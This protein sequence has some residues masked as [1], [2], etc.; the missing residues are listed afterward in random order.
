M[1]KQSFNAKLQDAGLER[2]VLSAI[3]CHGA[4]LFLDMS[5]LLS[6]SDFYWHQNQ[7]LYHV[8]SFLVKENDTQIFDVPTILST[9]K[10]KSF[11]L[12]ERENDHLEYIESLMIGPPDKDN[13]ISLSIK[14]YKLSLA[15]QGVTRL[16]DVKNKLVD[17]NGDEN[18]DDIISMIEDPVFDF[19]GKIV[20]K[21]NNTVQI[22]EN[23]LESVEEL[24]KNKQEMPG[25]STG[26]PKWDIALGGGL[27]RGTVT[28]VG[29]RPKIGKSF[30]CLNVANH[31]ARNG[32]PVLYLDTELTRQI[33]MLR[34]IS[35]SS[36]VLL[37]HVETGKFVENKEE[38]M[39]VWNSCKDIQSLPLTH[40]MIAGESIKN[41][42][43]SSRR[44]LTKTVGFEDN[45]CA[46][47]CLIIYDYLKL[48][49]SSDIKHNIQETQLL[50]FLISAIHD[51]STKYG[52][53]TLAT[54]Q[55]N[56]DGVKNDGGEFAAGSDRFLWLGSSFTILKKKTTTDLQED[57]PS[58]GLKKLLVTDT[59]F[60]PGMAEGEYINIIDNLSHAEFKEGLNNSEAMNDSFI[61]ETEI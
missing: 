3:M 57:P 17:I 35:L 48:T 19:T 12:F 18:I 31:M 25:L 60:G 55:L 53:P 2:S 28:V 40:S 1:S 6:A 46:K 45:G 9:C 44:W 14:L 50:G 13:A 56:R 51:F 29:A 22:G 10:S 59:R 58:N 24:A 34:L 52:I 61:N 54:V 4:S 16:V 36:E 38:K 32:I 47:P 20:S 42:L 33:Q 8:F 21:S 11:Q 15:R 26:Y 27:R 41:I 7:K 49:G 5:E 39:K 23:I 37:N 30:F 43:S